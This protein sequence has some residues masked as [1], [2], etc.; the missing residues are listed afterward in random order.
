MHRSTWI[1]ALLVAIGLTIAGLGA[2][3]ADVD[4]P[5]PTSPSSVAIDACGDQGACDCCVGD[6]AGDPRPVRRHGSPRG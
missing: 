1:S 4:R 2:A 5:W 3:S 6:G